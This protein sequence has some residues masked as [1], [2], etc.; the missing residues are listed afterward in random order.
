VTEVWQKKHWLVWIS[1]IL[2]LIVLAWNLEAAISFMVA[3]VPYLAAFELNGLPGEIA[4]TGTGL[5]FL[6]WQV[7]YFLAVVSPV[8]FRVSLIE[9]LVMQTIGLVGES[10][11]LTRITSDHAMLRSS[12]TRFILF[13]GIGV[14]LLGVALALVCLRTGKREV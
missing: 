4:V 5:L 10:I 6:M 12:I 1:R 14:V 11:L 3:P 9:A 2:I 13:D 7:P 8:R